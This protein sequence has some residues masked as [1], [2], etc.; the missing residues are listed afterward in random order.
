M[1]SEAFGNPCQPSPC[2]PNSQCKNVNENAVCSCLP[3]YSGT[4]PTCRPECTVSSECP[5]TRACIN[6]KCLDPC[7]GTCGRNANCRMIKHSPI[8]SC[9][10]SFTG[11]PFTICY[12]ITGR[13]VLFFSQIFIF[14]SFQIIFQNQFH[15]S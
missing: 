6:Q 7:P 15:Q 11:D 12:P 1:E 10:N 9:K 14:L 8:C 13:K 5:N 3:N 2:G 4:P